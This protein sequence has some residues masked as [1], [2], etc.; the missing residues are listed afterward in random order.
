VVPLRGEEILNMLQS[1]EPI[2]ND[3][4]FDLPVTV[5]PVVPRASVCVMNLSYDK[6]SML[7]SR[8]AR[9]AYR[10]IRGQLSSLGYPL[11]R[12]SSVTISPTSA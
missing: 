6:T 4:G 10:E 1:V 9:E 8:R 5:S 7:E 3:H 12:Q 2:A 11:Y